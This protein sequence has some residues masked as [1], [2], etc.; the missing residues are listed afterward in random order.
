M[1]SNS[2]KDAERDVR[3]SPDVPRTRS[4]REIETGGTPAALNARCRLAKFDDEELLPKPVTKPGAT[5]SEEERSRM[6]R[7]D[8]MNDSVDSAKDRP[9]S[10][11]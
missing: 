1:E 7:G 11:F 5:G 8:A 6:M 2:T 3:C 9:F 10:A 4:G